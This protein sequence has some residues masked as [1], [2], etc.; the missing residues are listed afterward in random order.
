MLNRNRVFTFSTVAAACL[1]VMGCNQNPPA[2]TADGTVVQPSTTT[3]N[4]PAPME[5]PADIALPADRDNTATNVRDR[6]DSTKLPIDQNENKIDI[7]ITADIRSQV[8]DTEMSVDAQNVKI[9]TQDGRVTLRGPVK[10]A[11]EKQRIEEIA[12]SVAGADKV[13]SLLEVTPE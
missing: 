7:G 2:T 13:D 4:R 5:Y 1:V 11:E 3:A 8:V 6:D 9:V 12:H 10:T